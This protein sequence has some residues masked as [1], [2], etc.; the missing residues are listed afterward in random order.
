MRPAIVHQYL[1]VMVYLRLIARAGSMWSICAGDHVGVENGMSLAF[2][3]VM[4]SRQYGMVEATQM[5][6]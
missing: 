4:P 1:L 3:V 6:I 2:H 5:I